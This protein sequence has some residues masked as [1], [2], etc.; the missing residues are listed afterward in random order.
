MSSTLGWSA[1]FFFFEVVGSAKEPAEEEEQRCHVSNA[2]DQ[3]FER[4]KEGQPHNPR[5]NSEHIKHTKYKSVETLNEARREEEEREERKHDIG[6]G[7]DLWLSHTSPHEVAFRTY[8]RHRYH[9]VP[10]FYKIS[11]RPI[12]L[13]ILTVMISEWNRCALQGTSVSPVPSGRAQ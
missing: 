3:E 1:E 5:F 4:R 9:I 10:R 7:S 12:R 2:R 6:H 13:S 8:R 11:M